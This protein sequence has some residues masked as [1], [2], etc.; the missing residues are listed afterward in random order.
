VTIFN[1]AVFMMGRIG[2]AELAAHSIAIQIASATFM[3]PVGLSQAAT[4]RVGRALGAGD[5]DGITRAGWTA[6]ALGV[7]F[8]AITCV[9]MMTTPTLLVSA[10]IDIANPANA[11]V[12]AAATSF[13][14]VAGVF[15]IVD[16]AQSVAAGALRGLQDTRVPMLYAAFGYWLLGFP[17]CLALGFWF[18]FGGIGIWIALASSLAVVAIIMVHRWVMRERLGLVGA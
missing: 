1:A 3:V 7:G 18:G 4:V 9:I 11:A 2:T 6:F 15:Q 12:V 13:L 5:R 14:F 17:L 16:G 10:F 8:M